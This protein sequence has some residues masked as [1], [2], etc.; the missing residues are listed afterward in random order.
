MSAQDELDKYETVYRTL[1]AK[2]PILEAAFK[3][4]RQRAPTFKLMTY[5]H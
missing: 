5:R 1:G 4:L 2:R 3:F